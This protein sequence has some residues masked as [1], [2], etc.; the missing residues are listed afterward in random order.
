MG[1]PMATI[2]HDPPFRYFCKH[3]LKN[4][5]VENQPEML[6]N[7]IAV[8]QASCLARAGNTFTRVKYSKGNRGCTRDSL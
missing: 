3:M 7:I 5:A 2:V 1:Q 6:A 4:F 8:L